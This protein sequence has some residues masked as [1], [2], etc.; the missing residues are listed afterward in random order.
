MSYC[1]TMRNNEHCYIQWCRKKC[2]TV[3]LVLNTNIATYYQYLN[4][5]H[6]HCVSF[7]WFSQEQLSR[8]E[9]ILL[10]NTLLSLHIL[11]PILNNNYPARCRREGRSATYETNS[12]P[13]STS[14]KI[15][16]SPFISRRRSDDWI[17]NFKL[18]QGYTVHVQMPRWAWCDVMWCGVVLCVVV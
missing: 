2:Y 3:T 15:E 14:H 4:L 10:E 5:C 8:K 6:H 9:I 13:I 7:Y 17:H 11:T 12:W 1:V 16:G 18:S